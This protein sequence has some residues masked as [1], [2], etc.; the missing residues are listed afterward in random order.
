M[1]S[2]VLAALA[3]GASLFM[4]GSLPARAQEK[5]DYAPYREGLFLRYLNAEPGEIDGVPRIGLSLG[6]RPLRA[7]IDSGSTGIVVAAEFVPGFET[8]PSLGPA[9]L[10]YSSSGRVML[11]QWVVMPVTLSGREGASVTTDPLPVLVVTE[12][13]CLDYARVCQPTNAPRNI[14]MV[15]VGFA[16]EGDSQSQSTP[17]KNPLLHVT[18]GEGARRQGY[19]LSPEGVH[20]GL[21]AANT[22][23]AFRYV[24]LDRRPDGTDWAPLP[25]CVA[26]GGSTL[27]ACGTVL[28]D[29]GVSV[30]YMTVPEAQAAGAQ[31]TLPPGTQ[32]AISIGTEGS[33]FPL[34]SFNAGDGGPMSPSAI[35]LRV[36]DDRTF[37]NT[38]YHLLNGFDVLFDGEGGY[39]GFRPR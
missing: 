13:Q 4:G 39:V 26:L 34:Y 23:G 16:R 5:P 32:V 1:R 33:A 27:P 17:D 11:G 14:A 29:T 20:V 36:A 9:K 12:V 24:K 6:G 25:G 22:R 21:T 35:H 30:M 3:I 15:G 7:V 18:G 28:V 37:V 38:S 10:T 19:I 31:G 2:R 8:M